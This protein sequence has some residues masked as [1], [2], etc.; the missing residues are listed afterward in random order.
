MK[1]LL[2][3]L[4]WSSVPSVDASWRRLV[5]A[6]MLNSL[7]QRRLAKAVC[8]QL[9]ERL[10]SSHETFGLALKN[11][12]VHHNE[13]LERTGEQGFRLRKVHAPR[14]A[15]LVLETSSITDYLLYGT[16]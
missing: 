11:L 8:S 1:Q 15:R 14:L 3:S 5:A 12:E 6:D 7:C 4:P 16:F 13:R 2:T 9:R 10:K